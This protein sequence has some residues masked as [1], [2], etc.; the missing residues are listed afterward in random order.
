MVLTH[1]SESESPFLCPAT[2]C[3][4]LPPRPRSLRVSRNA[5]GKI[6]T[7][8]K[9]DPSRVTGAANILPAWR[10]TRGLLAGTRAQPRS[11]PLAAPRNPGR[12]EPSR[13]EGPCARRPHALCPLERWAGGRPVTSR[14]LAL[15]AAG[16]GKRAPQGQPR[17]S[18]PPV[19]RALQ[20]PRRPALCPLLPSACCPGH[21]ALQSGVQAGR[22]WAA[23]SPERAGEGALRMGMGS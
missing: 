5:G 22:A 17:A 21:R 19:L 9:V 2:H 20:A 11:Q 18:G 6:L 16:E 1:R 7:Y 8:W 4:S 23:A 14:R 13:P 12:P 3:T 10:S 15:R